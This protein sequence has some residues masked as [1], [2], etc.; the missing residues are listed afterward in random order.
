MDNLPGK[1]QVGSDGRLQGGSFWG[2][3]GVLILPGLSVLLTTLTVLVM[4]PDV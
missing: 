3:V 2:A 4:M 1:A